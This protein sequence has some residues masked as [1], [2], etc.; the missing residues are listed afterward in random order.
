M[1]C[2]EDAHL[3]FQTCQ[4]DTIIKTLSFLCIAPRPPALGFSCQVL[5]LGHTLVLSGDLR[6]SCGSEFR[7]PVWQGAGV[8]DGSPHW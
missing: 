3:I 5:C 7:Q 6:T 1:P 2:Q 4:V 8:Q